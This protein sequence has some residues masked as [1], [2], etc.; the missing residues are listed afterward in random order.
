MDYVALVKQKLSVMDEDEKRSVITHR[1]YQ[2]AEQ[3]PNDWIRSLLDEAWTTRT[4]TEQD[5]DEELLGLFG[6][7]TKWGWLEFNKILKEYNFVPPWD[8]EV[9][10]DV[11][12]EDDW[13]EEEPTE[14]TDED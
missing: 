5:M 12:L 2:A 9:E 14:D 13:S 1:L 6:D 10:T 7:G 11:E 8:P 3:D 4:I